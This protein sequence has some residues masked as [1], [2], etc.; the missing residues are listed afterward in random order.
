LD[1]STIRTIELTIQNWDC[2]VH[3]TDFLWIPLCRTRITPLIF[4]Y[5]WFTFPSLFES[6]TARRRSSNFECGLVYGSDFLIW[7]SQ[8]RPDCQECFAAHS[9]CSSV[10]WFSQCCEKEREFKLLSA[11]SVWVSR[12]ERHRMIE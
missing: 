6:P 3:G 11:R 8:L 5:H 7:S 2:A 10:F 9:R 4:Q 12:M 1:S